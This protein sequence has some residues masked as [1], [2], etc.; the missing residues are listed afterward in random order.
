MSL[1]IKLDTGDAEPGIAAAQQQ[2]QRAAPGTQVEDGFCAGD[3][4]KMRQNHGIR[5][6][7]KAPLGN[8]QLDSDGKILHN[9]S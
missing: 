3:V 5:G 2:P 7:G 1:G 8:V 6:Q 9:V 4:G